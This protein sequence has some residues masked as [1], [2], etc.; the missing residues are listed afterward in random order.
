MLVGAVVSGWWSVVD[1]GEIVERER[2]DPLDAHADRDVRRT[3][4]VARVVQLACVQ[5]EAVA[6]RDDCAQY[7]QL[8]ALLR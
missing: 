6:S 7:T 5:V 3:G 1:E 2:A 4:Q 8:P